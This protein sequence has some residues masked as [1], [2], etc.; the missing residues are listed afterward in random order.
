MEHPDVEEASLHRRKGLVHQ[1]GI[2]IR[3]RT[4]PDD[5]SSAKLQ[6]D[7]DVRPSHPDPD[8]RQVAD[9]AGPWLLVVEVLVKK[10]GN[11]RFVAPDSMDAVLLAG[12]GRYK[13]ALFHD[14]PDPAPGDCPAFSK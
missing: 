6:Q 7:A 14:P 3:A 11:S 4:V 10:V 2:L 5:L 1:L 12:I 9:H 13:P 8:I